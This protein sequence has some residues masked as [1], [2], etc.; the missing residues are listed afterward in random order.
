MNSTVKS[1]QLRIKILYAIGKGDSTI[2]DLKKASGRDPGNI[3][4]ILKGF[5]EQ[6]LIE[7]SETFDH[8]EKPKKLTEEGEKLVEMVRSTPN[9]YKLFA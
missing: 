9:L 2:K 6:G 7:E 1:M 4:R 3:F 8:R 5:L